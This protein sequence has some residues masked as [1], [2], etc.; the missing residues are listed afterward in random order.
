MT[1]MLAMKRF[2]LILLVLLSANAFAA[3]NKWVDAD[4]RVNYSDLPPP[5]N[6]KAKP[7]HSASDAA[8][9]ASASG[10]PAASA[11]AAPKTIAERAAELDKA[12]QAKQEAAAKAAQEQAIADTKKANC[13][14]AQQNLR[15]LQA[16]T[17]IVE[18]DASGQR[19]Y[20]DDAQRQQRI[21]KAQQDIA[22]YCK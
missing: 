20:L 14:A 15:T 10:V 7:L 6:V 13:A 1:G 19:S 18:I 8:A 16:G 2:L 11:P 17:R 9:S 4:G 5:A 12:N 3:V 22:T 21:A